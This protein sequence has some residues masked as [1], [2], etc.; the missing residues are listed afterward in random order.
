VLQ[1]L[2]AGEQELSQDSE[3]VVGSVGKTCVSLGCDNEVPER[4]WYLL[5]LRQLLHARKQVFGDLGVK[6]LASRLAMSSGS[7]GKRLSLLGKDR[8]GAG[9]SGLLVED[10]VCTDGSASACRSRA[11]D[12][13]RGRLDSRRRRLSRKR[14]R[15]SSNQGG[16]LSGSQGGRLSGSQGGRLS[17]SQSGGLHSRKCGRLDATSQ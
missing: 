5:L 1:L 4:I 12:G 3:R 15:L 8:V 2:M 13:R 16:R 14:G 9:A 17:G 10:T 11:G 6:V 7:V